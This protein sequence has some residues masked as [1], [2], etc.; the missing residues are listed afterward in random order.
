MS[1]MLKK[2]ALIASLVT[3]IGGTLTFVMT[4]RSLGFGD[5]FM[6]SWL[7]TF[8][9][10]VLCI[11]P[12]GGVFSYLVHHLVDGVLPNLSELKQD[13]VFGLIMALIMESIMAVVTTINLHGWLALEVF[14]K[15][16]GATFL[17]ALPMG[18]A[19]SILMSLVIKRRLTVLLA[20]A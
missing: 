6:M 11:A 16:W 20:K 17:A 3:V 14:I 5:D 12:I 18:I 8:A 1:K 7:S 19:F 2:I 13:L 10:C 9:L 4:W 15:Q